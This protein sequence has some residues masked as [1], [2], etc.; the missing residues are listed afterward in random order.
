MSQQVREANAV[1]KAL[2]SLKVAVTLAVNWLGTGR[3]LLCLL[4]PGRGPCVEQP[5]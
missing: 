5:V 3:Q 1:V 2:P 4:A